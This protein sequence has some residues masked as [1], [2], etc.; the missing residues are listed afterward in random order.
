MLPL[1]SSAQWDMLGTSQGH[2]EMWQRALP[3]SGDPGQLFVTASKQHPAAFSSVCLHPLSHL[4][5]KYLFLH[6]LISP[7]STS[8]TAERRCSYLSCIFVV[9]ETDSGCFKEH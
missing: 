4:L 9:L 5:L 1:S 6:I 3:C 8:E 7:K 2:C